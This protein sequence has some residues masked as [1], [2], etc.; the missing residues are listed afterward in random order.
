MDPSVRD[1]WENLNCV[2]MVRR[3][4]LLGAGKTRVQT[5]Y[6]LSSLK[7]VSAAGLLGYIRGHRS[8]ENRCHWVLDAIYR[9]DHNQTRDRNSA[10]NH[11]T[12][13]RMALN[14]HN[15]MPLEGKK[16]KSLP[17]REMRANK[18]SAYLEQLL[19]LV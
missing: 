1:L 10:A 4:T 14:A 5:S 2:I 9:E 3:Q 6:Y 18:D 12:L 11:S 8:I 7:E 13:R 16:R 15:R 19:S 17:K